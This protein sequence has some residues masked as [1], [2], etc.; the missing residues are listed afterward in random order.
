MDK[1]IDTIEP[2]GARSSTLVRLHY[3]RESR[4]LVAEFRSASSAGTRVYA[5]ADVGPEAWALALDADRPGTWLRRSIIPWAKVTPMRGALWCVECGDY[6]VGDLHTM[7]RPH[8]AADTIEPG[9]GR[10]RPDDLP[11]GNAIAWMAGS[12][13]GGS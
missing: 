2:E 4:E 9:P 8:D 7:I 10:S 11:P 1:T 3:R 12:D 5:Y 13:E 6:V